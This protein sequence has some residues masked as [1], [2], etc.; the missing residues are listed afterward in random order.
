VDRKKCLFAGL[1]ERLI[2][3]T[4]V[5]MSQFPLYRVAK[6]AIWSSVCMNI[7]EVKWSCDSSLDGDLDVRM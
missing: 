5:N 3:Q 1:L 6:R 7:Q 4:N 2:V